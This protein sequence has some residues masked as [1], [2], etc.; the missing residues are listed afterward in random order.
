MVHSSSVAVVQ[1][2]VYGMFSDWKIRCPRGRIQ[3]F[4]NYN[5]NKWNID[6]RE[7]HSFQ[8]GT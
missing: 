1:I 7:S 5:T 8:A 6:L 4:Q 2:V 3:D